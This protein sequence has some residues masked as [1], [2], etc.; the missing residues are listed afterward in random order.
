MRLLEYLRKF[1]KIYNT[2]STKRLIENICY[3]NKYT[4]LSAAREPSWI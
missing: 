2:T 3:T 4:I 1:I